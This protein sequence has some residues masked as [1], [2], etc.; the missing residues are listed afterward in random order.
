MSFDGSTDLFRTN[1]GRIINRFEAFRLGEATGSEKIP[2]AEI[3]TL[4]KIVKNHKAK[5]LDIYVYENNNGSIFLSELRANKDARGQGLGTAFMQDLCGYAD[6][7]GKMIELNLGDKEAGGTTSK[8]RLIEFYKRF[9]FVRNF[10]RTKN[11]ALSCQM[12]RKPK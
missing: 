11:Y 9:G 2:E 12:Y 8:G 3:D 1:K 7:T 4:D 5:G 10:G 6:R